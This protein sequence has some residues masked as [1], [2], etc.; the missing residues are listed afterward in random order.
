MDYYK[1]YLKYKTKYLYFKNLQKGDGAA[2]LKI[3]F[4][5]ANI[6]YCEKEYSNNKSAIDKFVTNI[7]PQKKEDIFVVTIQE[8]NWSCK[9]AKDIIDKMKEKSNYNV[10][11][12]SCGIPGFTVVLL[13]FVKESLKGSVTTETVNLIWKRTKCSIV[14]KLDLT[15]N[16]EK[17]SIIFVGSHLP[18]DT[19]KVEDVEDYLGYQKRKDAFKKTLNVVKKYGD[20]IPIVWGGDMN[21]RKPPGDEEDQLTTYIRDP[22]EGV[23]FKEEDISKICPTCKIEVSKRQDSQGTTC[24]NIYHQKRNPSHCDRIIYSGDNIEQ[25]EY[26]S[27]DLP[28]SDHNGVK[29]SFVWKF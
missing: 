26:A 7:I 24:L 22:I 6:E 17:K 11:K 14:S 13:I 2:D 8:C 20:N 25:K 19:S 16:N 4:V 29:G 27:V 12:K 21:F 18:I 3:S 23:Q 1:K 5:T 28:C 9:I 10:F 15:Y